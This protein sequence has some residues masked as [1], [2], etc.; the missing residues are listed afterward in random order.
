MDQSSSIVKV[1]PLPVALLVLCAGNWL[2]HQQHD[3]D[4]ITPTQPL[5][6]VPTNQ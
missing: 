5:I 2:A 6:R 4:L 1:S 3:D